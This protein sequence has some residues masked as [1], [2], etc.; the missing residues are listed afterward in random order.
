MIKKRCMSKY[1]WQMFF[2]HGRRW[3]KGEF[4]VIRFYEV[5]VDG[6]VL[7]CVIYDE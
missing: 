3:K 6:K 4:H 1:R 2:K 7:I 5:K